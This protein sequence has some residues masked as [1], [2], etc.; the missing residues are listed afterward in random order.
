MRATLREAA[1][2]AADARILG[3]A[4]AGDDVLDAFHIASGT[5]FPLGEIVT[6]EFGL[7]F[8]EVPAPREL[9]TPT[10]SLAIRSRSVRAP[11]F[12]VV[13]FDEA[14]EPVV[15]TDLPV[16]T[17]GGTVSDVA[18][19]EFEGATIAGSIYEGDATI[20]IRLADGTRYFIEPVSRSLDG[21]LPGLHVL[22]AATDVLDTGAVCGAGHD[23]GGGNGHD[24]SHNH[25]H[26][27]DHGG[28]EGGIASDGGVAGGAACDTEL[29]VDCDFPFFQRQGSTVD[30]TAIRTKTIVSIVNQQYVA[31]ANIRHLLSGVV[32][33]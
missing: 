29:V 14:G 1:R 20:A 11:G 28:G 9:G 25:D 27:H 23:L 32:V 22:Y 18:G 4:P 21:A 6:G 26:N 17:V 13:S 33:R 3:P 12:A 16:H 5:V 30:G 24:H 10:L 15:D 7:R 2:D 8:L 19:Q 31:E